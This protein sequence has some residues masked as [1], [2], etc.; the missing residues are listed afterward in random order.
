[1]FDIF[2][3]LDKEGMTS[4]WKKSSSSLERERLRAAHR[5]R[6]WRLLCWFCE[7]RQAYPFGPRFNSLLKKLQV[8][9]KSLE[10]LIFLP[11]LPCCWNLRILDDK[12]EVLEYFF[13]YIISVSK[14][15]L[16]WSPELR[17]IQDGLYWFQYTKIDSNTHS[18]SL[19]SLN[20]DAC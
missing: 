15:T 11:Y 18:Q 2:A 1:M 19:K 16:S 14:H 10:L 13:Y 17:A 7:K 4:Q 20:V 3:V 6:M 8:S 12:N 5:I 9:L